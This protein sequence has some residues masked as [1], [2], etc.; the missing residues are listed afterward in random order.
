MF[1]FLSLKSINILKKNKHDQLS[2][3]CGTCALFLADDASG[4]CAVTGEYCK[5]P[6]FDCIGFS[7]IKNHAEFFSKGSVTHIVREF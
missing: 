1:L 7:D 4:W 5:Q 2:C 3:G 6:Q